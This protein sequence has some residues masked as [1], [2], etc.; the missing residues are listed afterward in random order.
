M[1]SAPSTMI[2]LPGRSIWGPRRSR[3]GR[4]VGHSP[5]LPLTTWHC[6]YFVFLAGWLLGCAIPPSPAFRDIPDRQ[7]TN[8]DSLQSSS[9]SL[10]A[11][12]C[13]L[14]I[15]ASCLHVTRRSYL[16]CGCLWFKGPATI[17]NVWPILIL[18]INTTTSPG[19]HKPLW[20]SGGYSA[21]HHDVGKYLECLNYV[22]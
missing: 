2:R 14:C 4:E 9:S 18:G 7:R 11:T 5:P 6:V 17:Y 12:R 20:T 22:P 1:A 19:C 13:C 3:R 21:R 15:D 8:S 16:G 10:K